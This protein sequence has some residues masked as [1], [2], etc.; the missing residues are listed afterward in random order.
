VLQSRRQRNGTHHDVSEADAHWEVCAE[1]TSAVRGTQPDS[2]RVQRAH[3]SSTRRPSMSG[4][5]GTISTNAL[6]SVN[7]R[8]C[9]QDG[10]RFS[11]RAP[12]PSTPELRS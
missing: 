8:A 4:T 1:T 7:R 10:M 12:V 6:T 11:S 2:S 9:G 5:S 3:E